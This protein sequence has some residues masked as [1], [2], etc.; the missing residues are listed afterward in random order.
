ML[1]IKVK[2]DI[3]I[4]FDKVGDEDWEKDTGVIIQELAEAWG[5]EPSEPVDASVISTLEERLV[6]N[7]PESLKLFYQSFGVANIGEALLGPDDVAPIKG[8]W[9]DEPQYGPDFTPED[10]ELLP[11]LIHFSDGTG[12][13]NMICFHMLTKEVYF[14]DHESKPYFSRLFDDADDY[15]KACLVDCQVEL[16]DVQTGQRQVEVWCDEVL[17]SL[18]GADVVDRWKGRGTGSRSDG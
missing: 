7:L 14:F 18:F 8:I 17:K 13:G 5:D 11:Y 6:L 3:V 16:F 1:E 10:Q 2:S 9:E 15:I 4:P 12:G